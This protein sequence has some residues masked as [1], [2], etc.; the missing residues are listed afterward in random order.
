MRYAVPRLI[1]NLLNRRVRYKL[2]QS[3]LLDGSYDAPVYNQWEI[4]H[5]T[6]AA[7][8]ESSDDAIIS[9]TLDGI[10]VTW[11]P[12]AFHIFGYSAEETIG[13]SIAMLL[14]PDRLNEEA[15]IL[16][17]LRLGERVE[18]L[19]TVRLTKDGREINVSI[20]CS[21][22]KDRG[23]Q[24]IGASK[25]ARDI[26]QKKIVEAAMQQQQV[27]VKHLARQNTM[28]E[29]AAGLAHELNQPLACIL[30]YA[31]AALDILRNGQASTEKVAP[32]LKEVVNETK[33]AG[34]IIRRL[35]DFIRKREP[36]IEL[37]DLNQ[38]IE[39]AVHL[40]EHDLRL[41]GIS[42]ELNLGQNLP[43][44]NADP[45]QFVQVMVNLVRN[46]R[47]AML[48]ANAPGSTLT[49]S[50]AFDGKEVRVDVIDRGCGVS[51]ENLHHLFDR[52]Y[53]TKA[54]GL[55]MGLAISKSIVESLGGHLSAVANCLG[56]GM[57]FC[58]ALQLQ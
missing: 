11:N 21:P 38:T 58:I 3:I 40:L 4:D 53:T 30:N 52:F 19:E 54:N 24:I 45:V 7:I 14:P 35:R 8:V 55:G 48:D 43:K 2:S 27:E 22:I 44:V 23:G 28:G 36:S 51:K 6:L 9:K 18:H 34:E 37:V 16:A 10:I 56:G 47:D 33:R 15:T 50:S 26:T 31:S 57:K 39:D 49:I 13:R 25:I 42:V 29:M 41:A 5:A 1:A 20:T 17:K 32:A 46:A 12:A